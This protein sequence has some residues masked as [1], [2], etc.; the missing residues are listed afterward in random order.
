MW[1]S[2]LMM[3]FIRRK[4]FWVL[5][6]AVWASIWVQPHIWYARYIPHLWLIPVITASALL[7]QFNG[8]PEYRRQVI[9]LVGMALLCMG[10][11]S[12]KLA[13]SNMKPK[14][15]LHNG[16]VAHFI[17]ENPQSL[18]F[19]VA[20]GLE[21]SYFRYSIQTYI[22]DWFPD[23]SFDKP[24]S[25]DDSKIPLPDFLGWCPVYLVADQAELDRLG[26]IKLS[27]WKKIWAIL[28]IRGQQ[29]KRV[30]GLG[31]YK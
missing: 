19:D 11:S 17:R 30:W 7:S 27:R 3:P 28:S 18:F 14:A 10:V 5:L 16:I 9:V 25:A 12:F 29:F 15:A 8:V 24:L 2:L 23:Y 20:D 22:S 26:D 6:I 4:E 31:P 13:A 21:F 1:F